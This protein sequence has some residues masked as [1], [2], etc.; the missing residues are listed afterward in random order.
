MSPLKKW[1]WALRRT[2][3]RSPTQ[4]VLRELE[5]RGLCVH[6]MRALE[7][8]AHCG[9]LH[10]KDFHRRVGGLEAWELDAQ[11]E[12]ALRRNLPGA[13]VKITDSYTEIRR[14]PR[15]FDLIIIDNPET[16]YGDRGQYCEHF[17]MLLEVL[18]VAEDSAVLI[19]NALI[20]Y[21]PGDRAG[22][23]FTKEQLEYRRRFYHTNHPE[24]MPLAEM[25]PVYYRLLDANGFELEWYF[26]VPRSLDKRMHYYVLK[27]KRRPAPADL[28]G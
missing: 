9:F 26:T 5:R 25:A 6:E 21:P 17:Q 13:E 7:L 11:Q 22:R 3:G 28:K 16:I 2:L 24:W 1:L 8:F 4:K 19:M 14:T 18:R 15:H 10:S 12:P 27:T 23:Q 20:G